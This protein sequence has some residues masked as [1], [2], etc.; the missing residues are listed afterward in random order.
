MKE[1]IQSSSTTPSTKR[2]MDEEAE[3]ASSYC[4][5]THNNEGVLGS[6]SI[7]P[8]ID[9]QGIPAG[10]LLWCAACCSDLQYEGRRMRA[11]I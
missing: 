8:H 1:I 6:P 9:T 4:D 3:M 10:S 7:F 2:R 5:S 11:R